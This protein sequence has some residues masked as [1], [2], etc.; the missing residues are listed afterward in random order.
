MARWAVR[1]LQCSH[2]GAGSH[3]GAA[4]SSSHVQGQQG[5]GRP[6]LGAGEEAPARSRHAISC[7]RHRRLPLLARVTRAAPR[8]TATDS[9]PRGVIPAVVPV[10]GSLAVGWECVCKCRHQRSPICTPPP[11]AI[12]NL[13]A[14]PWLA[15]AVCAG[16][17]AGRRFTAIDSAPRGVL[18]AVVPVA[19]APER[20]RGGEGDVTPSLAAATDGSRCLRASRVPRRVSPPSIAH[21]VP[22]FLR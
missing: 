10:A 20:V 8:V 14:D 7:R 2:V 12:T 11:P 6:G 16:R 17:S 4:A 9:A 13:Y 21:P 22:C 5:R 1:G 3:V 18:S 15:P 19:P